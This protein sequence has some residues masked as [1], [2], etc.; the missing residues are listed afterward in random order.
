MPLP[1]ITN[2]Q[3][4]VN[5]Y[6]YV[7]SNIFE[8]YFTLPEALRA[9]FAKDEALLTEHVTK[10]TGLDALNRAPG[11]VQQKFMGTDRSFISTKIDNTFAEIEIEFTL[12]LRNKTDNYIYKLFKAWKNLGYNIE[13]GERHLKSEYTADW[14]RIAVGN[15]SGD[16]YRD[17][18]FKDVMINGDISGMTEYD[19]DSADPVVLGV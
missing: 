3:A 5:K 14:L 19:Y 18:I 2:S 17:I 4:G 8:V 7:P 15:P 16:I 10:I 12:N 1:H 6:D 13:T 9:D 11:V